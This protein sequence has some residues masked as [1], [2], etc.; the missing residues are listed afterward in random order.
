MCN[1]SFWAVRKLVSDCFFF[2]FVRSNFRPDSPTSNW[3]MRNN[4][5]YQFRGRV[6]DYRLQKSQIA[7]E[8]VLQNV[9]HLFCMSSMAGEV[10]RT[11]FEVS[12][13]PN[14]PFRDTLR[15]LW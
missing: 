6:Y 2:F 13:P 4:K 12:R 5:S 3:V 8:N 1:F 9:I 14:A 10:A 11:K 15:H 7:D